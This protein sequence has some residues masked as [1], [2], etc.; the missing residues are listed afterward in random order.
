MSKLSKEYKNEIQEIFG[1]IYSKYMSLEIEKIK[2]T[3][4]KELSKKVL[5]Y[6]QE[7]ITKIE[8]INYDSYF[9]KLNSEVEKQNV[10]IESINY[11]SHFS[12]LNSEVE[13]QNVKIESIANN[14][15]IEEQITKYYKN[16]KIM[17][18]ILVCI[19]IIVLVLV[20]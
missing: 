13:K 11:D 10:K 1:E 8:S 3:L 19:N 12:K 18:W 6:K 5:N 16:F 20:F 2:E 7:I 17:L 14:R 4:D 9:S 15:S